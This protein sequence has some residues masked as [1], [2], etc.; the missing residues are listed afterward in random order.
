ML[1][2]GVGLAAAIV[3]GRYAFANRNT[4]QPDAATPP[5]VRPTATRSAVPPTQSAPPAAPPSTSQNPERDGVFLDSL[6]DRGI[7]FT[8]PDAAVYNGKMVCTNL[9]SGM[10][11]QQV[12]EALRNSSP[13]LGEKT[14]AY[15]TISVRTYCPTYDALLP[16]GS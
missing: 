16:P 2:V 8:N 6:H 15:V 13:A 14:T 1:M 4:D 3:L 5:T 12:V 7:G 9:S 10:T 11:V